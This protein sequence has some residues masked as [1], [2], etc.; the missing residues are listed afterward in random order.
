[1]RNAVVLAK[2]CLGA[3]GLMVLGVG[4]TACAAANYPDRPDV[5]KAQQ[6]WCAALAK[7]A[8]SGDSW[9]RMSDCQGASLAASPAYITLMTK[10]YSEQ[11]DAAK[12]AKDA[13]ADDRSLLIAGCRDNVLIELPA[14]SPGMDEVLNAKCERAVRCEKNV[15]MENCIKTLKTTEP[16]QLAMFSTVYNAAALHQVAGCL[17]GGCE[18][19]EEEAVSKCYGG[20]NERLL[21]T[22]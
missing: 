16:A 2:V 9:D 21:W 7:S 8:G 4:F 20:V 19:N 22:P 18:D 17:S 15:T 13:S 10:C 11:Y 6:G 14:S 1:M 5:A 12:G 3:A